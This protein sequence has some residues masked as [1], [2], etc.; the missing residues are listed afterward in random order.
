MR[1]KNSM[2]LVLLKTG[3]MCGFFTITNKTINNKYRKKEIVEKLDTKSI[4]LLPNSWQRSIKIK[5]LAG[6][7]RKIKRYYEK[8]F[9]FNYQVSILN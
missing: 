2:P 3:L 8:L 4:A 6:M 9:E 5:K 7:S 1:F